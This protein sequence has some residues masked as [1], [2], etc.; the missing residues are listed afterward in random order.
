MSSS[1]MR[2]GVCALLLLRL[3]A[4][5]AAA[6]TPLDALRDAVQTALDA[7]AVRWNASFQVG[8]S[9]HGGGRVLGEFGV[10]AG[11]N[12]RARGVAMRPD[13]MVPVGSAT[14]AYTAAAVVRLVDQHL[15]AS[16][17]D[18]AHLYVDPVLQRLNGTTLLSLWG[19]DETIHKVTVRHLLHMSS[20]LR[21]YDDQALQRFTTGYPGED[22]TPID[23]LHE[24]DKSFLF[25]PGQGAAYT[26]VGF[27]LLGFVAVGASAPRGDSTWTDFDQRAFMT[28]DQRM[29]W[30]RTSFP[31]MGRCS[32]Y[33]VAHTYS[34]VS[35][36]T[37][38]TFYDYSP[39]SCLNG[40]TCGNMAA[41]AHN[42]ASFFADLL[43]G[44]IV[45]AEGLANMTAFSP[46]TQGFATGMPYG[47]GLMSFYKT[48]PGVRPDFAWIGHA[49]QD[50][51]SGAVAAGY[52]T[53]WKFGFAIT[54]N[55]ITG[56]NCSG[57]TP[58][59]QGQS[60]FMD[61]VLC[62][63]TNLLVDH[64]S[65]GKAHGDEDCDKRR[66]EVA[67]DVAG[68]RARHRQRQRMA[69]RHAGLA[70]AQAHAHAHA[71]RPA[72]V[73]A[74]AGKCQGSPI[75]V[76]PYQADGNCDKSAATGDPRGPFYAKVVMSSD[77][78]L[79]TLSFWYEQQSG[80]DA[81]TCTGP[82][83]HA[84]YP[85]SPFTVPTSTCF[86]TGGGSPYDIAFAYN[87]TSKVLVEY[88]WPATVDTTCAWVDGIPPSLGP[89]P[90]PAPAPAPAGQ[91]QLMVQMYTSADC[92]PATVNAAHG[93]WL[94]VE[95]DTCKPLDAAGHFYSTSC[96]GTTVTNALSCTDSECSQGCT[97]V[98]SQL[99]ACVENPAGGG[100]RYILMGATEC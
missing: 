33:E 6:A 88:V 42:I 24:L 83:S 17:D 60:R 48:W 25:A 16:L 81:K 94:A 8:F 66:E 19:G 75:A 80:D 59:L 68:A 45:S 51:A 10:A 93:V 15:I 96:K 99:D 97:H 53:K 4:G 84:P 64:A 82:T 7:E 62:V 90:P 61:H 73:V 76:V 78:K 86:R 79:A 91:K 92:D 63:V 30:N 23:M 54:Q 72:Q 47:L 20:G 11:L 77:F 56:M 29:R 87:A 52:N 26:S 43:E 40:W 18:P 95:T 1:P 27:V 55:S 5:A 35:V 2:R 70:Q 98:S 34:V 14:K 57:A 67:G 12:D 37:T 22:K 36:N 39:T 46:F 41:S 13:D 38:A 3:L 85:A 100:V 31:M 50:Y 21:D 28:P 69:A 65:G 32:E 58:D 49:G 89:T 9:S 71:H 74:G 44:R